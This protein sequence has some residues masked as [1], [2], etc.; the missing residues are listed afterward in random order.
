MALNEKKLRK[1]FD[2]L[3]PKIEPKPQIFKHCV[4]AFIVGGLICDVG[5][6]F[7]NFFLTMGIPKDEV[8]T[9]VSIVMVFIGAFL[10]GIGVYDKIAK[11]AGAG[12]VV[13]ITGF[14]NSIVSPAMEFKQEG[15]VFGV[16]AKMFVIAGPVLVYGIGSSV[17]VGLIYFIMS[18]L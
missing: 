16:A 18:K 14:A 1:D 2:N 17:I 7:N 10:T 13:P 9:Y 4:S 3:S 11:F 6:F 12:T 8:G 5:Q 15:Y